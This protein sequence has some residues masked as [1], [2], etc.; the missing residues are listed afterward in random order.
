VQ[1]VYI[2]MDASGTG[3]YLIGKCLDP[4]AQIIQAPPGPI[5]AVTL[6]GELPSFQADS[7]FKPSSYQ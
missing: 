5:Q 1:A 6:D 2:V 7:S 3:F 4:P